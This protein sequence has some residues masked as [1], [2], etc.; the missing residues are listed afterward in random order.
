MSCERISQRIKLQEFL[1]TKQET[2]DLLDDIEKNMAKKELNDE[3]AKSFIN[4]VIDIFDVKNPDLTSFEGKIKID[5]GS[6]LLTDK[7][8]FFLETLEYFGLPKGYMN[9]QGHF[10]DWS[11]KEEAK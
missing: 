10:G 8:K 11:K 9:R 2:I 7:F 5:E 3:F 4:A 1:K 6:C